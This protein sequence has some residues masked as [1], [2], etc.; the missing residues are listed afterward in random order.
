[1]YVYTYVYTC[2]F[3]CKFMYVSIFTHIYSRTHAYERIFIVRIYTHVFEF[4]FC[5]VLHIQ[6]RN[7]FCVRSSFFKK[8]PSWVCLLSGL[9]IYL[10]TDLYVYVFM[11]I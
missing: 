5:G 4:L 8:N 3:I 11:Y 6:I 2:I 7:F 9:F 10:C 1:M